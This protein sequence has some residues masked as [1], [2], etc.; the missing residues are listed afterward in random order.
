MS[1]FEGGDGEPIIGTEAKKE[2]R[3]GLA[4]GLPASVDGRQPSGI[5]LG[6]HTVTLGRVQEKEEEGLTGLEGKI[7]P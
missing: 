1:L 5:G 7:K 3:K 6:L 4:E 2:A